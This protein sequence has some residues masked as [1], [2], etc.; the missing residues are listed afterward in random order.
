M[1]TTP[2][3]GPTAV[4]V[5]LSAGEPDAATL[6]RAAEQTA[7]T[8]LAPAAPHRL[9]E[10]VPAPQHVQPDP[11]ADWV[12]P[13]DAV[14]VTSANP[15]ALAVAE[16]LAQLL[17]P[18]TGYP[19]PV[20]DATTP[21]PAGGIALVLDDSADLGAEGYSADL[22]AEGYSADLGAEGYSADLGAEGYSADLGAE[23]YSADLG[24]EGYSADLG[25]VL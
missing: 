10:V 16:Q 19:L 5:P 24:A 25:A 7:G 9:A 21:E 3:P 11:T 20:T 22:G 4:P 12:L 17:R 2:S 13:A 8:L 14:I 18:A 23:G 6:A 1:S 15:A